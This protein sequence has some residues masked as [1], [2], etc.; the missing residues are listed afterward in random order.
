MTVAAAIA[1]ISEREGVSHAFAYPGTSELGLCSAIASSKVRL[2]NGRGDKESAFMAAGGSVLKAAKTVAILHGARGLSN[3]LGALCDAQRNEV[4]FVNFVGLPSTS[5][6]PFLPPHGE[7]NLIENAARF[8]KAGVDVSSLSQERFPHEFVKNVRWAFETAKT[9]PR[10]PVLIGVPQ[11]L[12]EKSC[13]PRAIIDAYEPSSDEQPFPDKKELCT[14]ADLLKQSARPLILIDDIY[15]KHEGADKALKAFSEHLQAPVLQVFYRRGPMLFQSTFSRLVPLFAGRYDLSNKDDQGLL[16]SADCII[17]LE[18][19]NM[20]SRVIGGLPSCPKI[21]ITS[22]EKMTRKNEYLHDGDCL[23][24]GD[25]FQIMKLLSEAVEARPEDAQKKERCRRQMSAKDAANA[26]IPLAWAGR[27]FAS[28]IA[29]VFE[30]SP[31]LLIDDSQMFGGLLSRF[32][33]YLPADIR[34]VGDHGAFIGGGL[35]F[36]TGAAIGNKDR[37]V[38]CF[39]GD[40]SFVNAVQGLVASGEQ[41]API[42]YVVC[43]NG[44]SVSLLT[45][46]AVSPVPFTGSHGEDFLQNVNRLDYCTIAE[47]LGVATI[48]VRL[49]KDVRDT[50]HAQKLFGEAL[51]KADSADGPV[52]IELVMTSDPREWGGI[53]ATS[54]NEKIMK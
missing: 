19:R 50:S 44:K 6:A 45:Q 43:N 33:E 40:Q 12:L 27:A 21:A 11:D 8:V 15:F 18:D 30:K 9:F 3:A 32:Y 4:G 28:A 39:L 51:R 34:V 49:D 48:R 36:S 24:A 17:T 22:N 10:G 52:L 53:W 41:K 38:V 37:R 2:V 16:E 7:R 20:Y 13:I 31:V 14:A 29:A 47:A 5:S 35:S 46:S 26:N 54:G 25:P 23:L 1:K 42:T